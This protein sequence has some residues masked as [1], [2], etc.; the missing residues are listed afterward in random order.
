VLESNDEIRHLLE[1]ATLPT[2]K[3]LEVSVPGGF[4]AQVQLWLPPDI[5]KSGKTK[6]PLLINV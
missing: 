4:K 1:G 6:F 5:D 2:T 3:Q